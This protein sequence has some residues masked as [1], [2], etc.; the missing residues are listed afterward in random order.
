MQAVD[1]ICE[2]CS[3]P[4]LWEPGRHMV[5][6]LCRPLTEEEKAVKQAERIVRLKGKGR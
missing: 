4:I 6:L 3:K 2:R 1:A 5:C